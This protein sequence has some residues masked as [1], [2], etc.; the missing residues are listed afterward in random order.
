MRHLHASETLTST[1]MY[2]L[3][4]HAWKEDQNKDTLSHCQSVSCK[5]VSR[6]YKKCEW[7]FGARCTDVIAASPCAVSQ[8]SSV[9]S[10]ACKCCQ[11]ICNL[12]LTAHIAQNFALKRFWCFTICNCDSFLIHGFT[13]K[14]WIII[15][16]NRVSYSFNHF[17]ISLKCIFS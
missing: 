10:Q 15:L 6:L 14:T 17:R 3:F 7:N 13:V 5:P 11:N 4:A 1:N 2:I 16:Q 8:I 12:W 9:V